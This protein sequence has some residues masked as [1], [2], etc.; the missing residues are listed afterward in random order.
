L[1]ESRGSQQ[2]QLHIYLLFPLLFAIR[3]K[4]ISKA[5]SEAK[6]NAGYKDEASITKS[7][8]QRISFSDIHTQDFWQMLFPKPKL[9]I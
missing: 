5:F 8:D 4:K 1:F 7:R 6:K 3:N 9:E 2:Q